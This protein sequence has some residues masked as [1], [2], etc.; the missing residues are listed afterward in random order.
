MNQPMDNS[1]SKPNCGT[2]YLLHF[3]Q[4][5]SHAQHYVGFTTDLDKRLDKHQR[6]TGS[7]LCRAIKLA[8]IGFQLAR[9]WEGVDRAF[10]R[11]LHN[12]HGSGRFCPICKAEI[13]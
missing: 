4:K 1:T 2:V 10:E 11:K 9:T 12:R 8:G 5:F 6:G 7:K 3:D 13:K